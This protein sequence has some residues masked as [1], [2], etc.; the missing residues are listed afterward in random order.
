MPNSFVSKSLLLAASALLVQAA[1]VAAN[2]NGAT[3]VSQSV[4]NAMQLGKSYAVSVTYKNTGTSTWTSGGNYRLGSQAPYDTWRWGPGRVDLPAGVQVPPNGVYTFNFNV[5]VSDKNF[6][7]AYNSQLSVCDFQWGLVQDG[8]E[9]LASGGNTEVGL[10]DAP[11]VSLAYP[12]VAAPVAVSATAFSAANFRGANLLMQTYE[13]DQL[14]DHTAWL[15]DAANAQIIIDKAASMGLNVLRVPVILPPKVPGKPADWMP[16]SDTYKGKCP[17]PNKPEWGTATD[18]AAITQGII[19][20]MKIIMSKANA[21]NIKVIP[22][23]DGYTKYSE[24]CYWKKSYVDVKDN[25]LLLING[26][27][28][29]PALLAWDVMNEPLW[30]AVAFDCLHSSADYASVVNAVHAMYNLV[31]SNDAAHPTT[32]GEYQVPLLKYWKDIS[33]FASPHL[34]VANVGSANPASLNQINYVQS[35]SMREMS[36]ALGTAMPLVIGEFGSAD[37]DANFNGGF[38]DRFLNGL[39]VEGRGF[40]LWSISNSSHQQ[41]FSVINTDGSLKPAGVTLQRQQWYPLIQQLYLG[42]T[43][44]PADPGAL[45]NFAAA[46]VSLQQDMKSRSLTLGRSLSAL[47]SAYGTEPALRTLI[48]SLYNSAEFQAQYTPA[49][50]NNYVNQIFNMVFKRSADAAGLQFW[51]DQMNYYGLEKSRAVISIMAAGLTNSSAQGLLDA[52]TETRKAAVAG[53]YSASLNTPARVA[54]Y[55]GAAATAA[56]RSL[57]AAVTSSTDVKAYQANINASLV[58]LCGQ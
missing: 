35:A 38:Y 40:M 53:N 18:S 46:L 42:Y 5:T 21:A 57:L 39:T 29:E 14:C 49:N 3:F 36:N 48:D 41:G 16:N 13:D 26:L 34:Y 43:G 28:S 25:A 56:G 44:R 11:A 33:S 12:P 17:L 50:V 19:A 9:W 27:K 6:C 45:N 54:C 24:P 55:S 23:I 4:P 10:F 47:D 51:A 58:S 8:V 7:R 32:V 2:G 37:A 30:N 52:A 1:A 31:R 15:P 20:K 22:I